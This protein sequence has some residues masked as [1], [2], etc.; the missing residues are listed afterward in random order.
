MDG[1]AI[2]LCF[3]RVLMLLRVVDRWGCDG[4]LASGG[5]TRIRGEEGAGSHPR[6]CTIQGATVCILVTGRF[7]A[8]REGRMKF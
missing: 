6:M 2:S 1:Q 3:Q 7:A 4:G 5:V 8:V